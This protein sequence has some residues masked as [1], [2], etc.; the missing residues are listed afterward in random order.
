M[1]GVIDSECKFSNLHST[2][3]KRCLAQS[4]TN[5]TLI[6]NNTGDAG[7]C[8]TDSGLVN[9][10]YYY[11]YHLLFTWHSCL[12][13][14]KCRHRMTSS[15]PYPP[16]NPKIFVYFFGVWTFLNQQCDRQ[17]EKWTKETVVY[18]KN[19][20]CLYMCV[21]FMAVTDTVGE[22]DF[23]LGP[24]INWWKFTTQQKDMTF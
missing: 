2:V 20:V 21:C 5:G 10:K 12:N 7:F 23:L 18:R 15:I 1:E 13:L 16:K 6:S 14:W 4:A 8:N 3:Y 11:C 9:N 22:S 24:G 19:T 17:L